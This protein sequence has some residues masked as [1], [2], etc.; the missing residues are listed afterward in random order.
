[1]KKAVLF[2]MDGV[3]LDSETLHMEAAREVLSPYGVEIPEDMR[4]EFM[5]LS[6][7][8]YWVRVRENFPKLPP[9][10]ALS[11]KKHDA[12]WEV[13]KRSRLT[14][15]E[16][17]RETLSWLKGLGLKLA[18]VSSTPR[19][20]V[21]YM[22]EKLGLRDLFDVVVGGDEVSEGK[23]SPQSYLLAAQRLGVRPIECIV[24]EDSKNGIVAGTRASMYVVAFRPPK[25]ARGLAEVEVFDF[26]AL[27]DVL[28]RIFEGTAPTFRESKSSNQKEV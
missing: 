8:E 5:G 4:E 7:L 26:K 28:Y 24:I 6:E 3:L 1:V 23:P 11:E 25:K 10:E 13:I 9:P 22:L 12:F 19:K 20:Q 21:E 2:D 17:A 18:V 15:F 16:G 27:K 14:P